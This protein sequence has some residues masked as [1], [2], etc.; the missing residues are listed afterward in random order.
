MTDH[1]L[2]FVV[3]GTG[4]HG[5][6]YTS[7]LFTEAG[8]PTGHEQF[9][10]FNEPEIGLVGDSSWLAVPHLE[11]LDEQ[12]VQVYHQTRHPIESLRS[13]LGGEMFGEGRKN[14]WFAVR[15][16]YLPMTGID[17]IDAMRIYV[18]WN[19]ACERWAMSRWQVEKLDWFNFAV[20]AACAQVEVDRDQFIKAQAM[21]PSN[22]NGH[23]RNEGIT[24]DDLP[25]GADK[26]ALAM[27]AEH[28]GYDL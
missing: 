7:R 21:V 19:I 14:K 3:V 25:S 15:E 20:V 12:G 13:M 18:Q 23:R 10:G 26:D 1:P 22:Y 6:G 4:R 5:S 11:S 2:Q 28:Y 8:L 16:S 27:L 24:F 17:V 9:Y